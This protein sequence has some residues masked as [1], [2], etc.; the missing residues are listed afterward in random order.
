MN[1]GATLL[2]T[3]ESFLVSLLGANG[4]LAFVFAL[5]PLALLAVMLWLLLRKGGW[6][7]LLAVLA[8][9]VGGMQVVTNPPA[10]LAFLAIG[11]GLGYVATR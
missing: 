4:L 10:S 6:L 9:F 1:P 5:L 8:A 7:G 3:L 2:E 11:L